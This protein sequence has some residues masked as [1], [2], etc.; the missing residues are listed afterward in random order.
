M[1]MKRA[2][3]ILLR[4]IL[5]ALLVVM[6]MPLAMLCTDSLMGKQEIMESFGAVLEAVSYTHLTLPTS[7]F[8]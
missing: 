4:I 1:K 2:W 6:V 8:V 5:A 7:V 3:E